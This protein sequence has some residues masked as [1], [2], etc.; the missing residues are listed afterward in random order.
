VGCAGRTFDQEPREAHSNYPA[1]PHR[2]REGV[3]LERAAPELALEKRLGSSGDELAQELALA[4]EWRRCRVVPVRQPLVLISQIHRSGGTF[5]S[6][7]FDGHPQ[8][9][10]HPFELRLGP[11]H[12]QPKSWP[13]IDLD[14]NPDT[15]WKAVRERHVER[16]FVDGYQ[17]ASA[18]TLSAFPPG[19]CTGTP[20]VRRC[21]SLGACRVKR[22]TSST[23]T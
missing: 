23:R 4:A 16:H 22:V 14:A 17:K 8:C 1:P 18:R 15:W 9:H 11:S 2:G 19:T 21:N 10:A 3:R 12:G 5:L 6:Q 20:S 13:R 7:L